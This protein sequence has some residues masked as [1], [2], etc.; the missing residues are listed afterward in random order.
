M[1]PDDIPFIYKDIKDNMPFHSPTS[2]SIKRTYTLNFPKNLMDYSHHIDDRF[3]NNSLAEI[4]EAEH[5]N[6][7][8]RHFKKWFHIQ[9]NYHPVEGNHDGFF[10]KLRKYVES[11][12]NSSVLACGFLI[13]SYI[14]S[15][16]HVDGNDIVTG[17]GGVDIG[18]FGFDRVTCTRLGDGTVGEFYDQVALSIV[19]SAGNVK[20]AVYDNSSDT[21][22]NL[23]QQESGNASAIAYTFRS[24]TDFPLVTVRNWLGFNNTDGGMHPHWV[25]GSTD[26]RWFHSSNGDQTYATSFLTPI[27]TSGVSRGTDQAIGKVGH[28]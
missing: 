4:E 11:D 10:T 18:S 14:I 13:N 8:T 19:A 28:S 27:A 3:L 12:M 1:K 7:L 5:H 21:P 24:L 15:S 25:S 20:L 22:V 6:L 16:P 26:N 2:A 9:Q 17:T 23:Y